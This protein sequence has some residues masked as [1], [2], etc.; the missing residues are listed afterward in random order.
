[1]AKP[2]LTPA[3]AVAAALSAAAS[4]IETPA[5]ASLPRLGTVVN[6]TVAPGAL[7]INNETGALFEDG[8]ATPQTVTVTTLRRLADGDLLLT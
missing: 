3:V 7:L 1:M 5:P 8:V 4:V 6:V 2:T